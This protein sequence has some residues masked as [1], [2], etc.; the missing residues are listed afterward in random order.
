[1]FQS[2]QGTS[3]DMGS[4][5]RTHLRRRVVFAMAI[6]LIPLIMASTASVLFHGTSAVN[7][8]YVLTLGQLVEGMAH[9][10]GHVAR[11]ES[12]RA[13]DPEAAVNTYVKT[14]GLYSALRAADPD[15]DDVQGESDSA[16]PEALA[17]RT[18]DLGIDPVGLSNELGL[19]GHEMPPEL[20]AIWE[21]EE[22]WSVLVD[23]VPSLEVSFGI[24]LLRAADIFV[25]KDHS[26]ATLD[27]FW[28][29]SGTVPDEQLAEVSSVLN[30]TSMQA[31]QAPIYLAGAVLAIVL[32]AAV[33]AWGLIV[34]P[35]IHEIV[36]I[37]A[38]LR[39]EADAARAA[40]RAKTQFLA[41]VSHE[42]RTPMNGVIGAAQLLE[43]SDLPEEDKEL[44]DI[45]NSCADGQMALIEEILTF[46]EIEAGAL[47]MEDEPM[48]VKKLMRNAT[49]FAT[50]LAN[51]KGL[52][53]TV[54][55]PK[56]AP[57]IL[58]DARRLR[59]VIVNL[60]GNAVKFTDAGSVIVEAIIEQPGASDQAEFRI[61]VTDTGPGIATDQHTRI[62]DRF[63]QGDSSSSRKAG[64]TGLGLSIAQGIAREAQ[65]DITLVSEL[66]QGSTFTFHMP[67]KVTSDV[68]DA[69]QDERNAA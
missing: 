52:E 30:Q 55:V 15:G 60:V 19:L 13:N 26:A 41:T 43:I 3:P 14:L 11:L 31:G 27:A 66:G 51:N 68:Q 34:R 22:E 45:L 9:L 61:V 17:D 20:A 47:S 67:T 58:G 24:T 62:F 57:E 2:P 5:D 25:D 63:S 28:A 35:L 7:T 69:S 18:V 64:G 56:D 37:Q 21:Q 1:M 32:A 6:L 42:L 8:R 12:D 10:N 4:I 54:I 49:S 65:G 39:Q 16:T 36:R 48:D 53:L 33:L 40:D 59:Q 46:G 23:E 50:I 38:A 29:A 44:V